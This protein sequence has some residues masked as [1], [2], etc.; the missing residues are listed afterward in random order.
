[1]Y[2]HMGHWQPSPWMFGCLSSDVVVGKTFYHPTTGTDVNNAKISR[3]VLDWPY[4]GMKWA[5][6]FEKYLW[7]TSPCEAD[8]EL[9]RKHS[10]SQAHE[11]PI[12]S[13]DSFQVAL[14]W[15]QMFN[16]SNIPVIA[17]SLRQPASQENGCYKSFHRLWWTSEEH[18]LQFW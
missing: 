7:A 17:L 15:K 4:W 18:I 5:L 14:A 9:D 13:L 8:M 6:L 1:M 12:F 11:Q 10:V 2:L 16:S 3:N